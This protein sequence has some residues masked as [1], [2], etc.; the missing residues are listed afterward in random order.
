MKERDMGEKLKTEKL[1][2]EMG[3]RCYGSCK[4]RSVKS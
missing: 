4:G 2:V 1:K 3:G